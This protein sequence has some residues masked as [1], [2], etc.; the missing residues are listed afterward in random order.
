MGKKIHTDENGKEYIMENNKKVYVT[1]ITSCVDF[2]D[3][4]EGLY[5]YLDKLG[6]ENCE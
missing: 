4:T 1:R 6:K 5:N 2:F 3:G